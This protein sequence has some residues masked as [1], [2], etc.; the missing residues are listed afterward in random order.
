MKMK[1][2]GFWIFF[3]NPKYF[4][5]DDFLKSGIT[6][7]TW[8]TYKSQK[9]LFSIGDKGV[10]RVGIDSRT[11]KQLNGRH[12]LKSGIYAIV[13]II[14]VPDYIADSDHVY[15]EYNDKP[16]DRVLRVRLAIMKNLIWE[17][18]QISYLKDINETCQDKNL[19]EGRQLNSLPLSKPAFEMIDLLTGPKKQL[20][21]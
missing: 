17:P 11:R 12:K 2:T 9:D 8:D 13:S 7:F 18:L 20:E 1:R 21:R 5:I 4:R 10:I 16:M 15:W 6:E 14:S 3:C 19:M